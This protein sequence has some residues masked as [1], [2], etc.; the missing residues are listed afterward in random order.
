M[1]K[2]QMFFLAIIN[3]A[4]MIIGALFVLTDVIMAVTGLNH[5]PIVL[6]AFGAVGFAMIFMSAVSLVFIIFC[7]V[8]NSG[9]VVA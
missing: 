8:A 6:T 9:K 5:S 7:D 2:I 1:S 4:T 3:L